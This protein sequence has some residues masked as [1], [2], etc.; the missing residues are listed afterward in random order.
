MAHCARGGLALTCDHR[1]L[2]KNGMTRDVQSDGGM[3]LHHIN[4]N[5][6]GIKLSIVRVLFQTMSAVEILIVHT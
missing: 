2:Q 1:S 6:Y 4:F 3:A 5:Y